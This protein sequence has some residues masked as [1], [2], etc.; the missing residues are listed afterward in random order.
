MNLKDKPI[1]KTR[2]PS[3]L[4]LGEQGA[5]VTLATPIK[6]A[7][8]STDRLTLRAPTVRDV[9]AASAIAQGN[10]EAHELALFASMAQ[11]A[12]RELEGLTLTDYHRL[13]AAY[14]CLVQDDELWPAVA[15]VAG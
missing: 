8:V 6:I 11:A 15:K 10:D 2:L 5:V 12:Q 1:D 4:Q 14:F 3:W 13:Q 7:D 9:R